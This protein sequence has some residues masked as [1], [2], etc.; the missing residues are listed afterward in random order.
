MNNIIRITIDEYITL[1]YKRYNVVIEDL[2]DIEDH[3][4]YQDISHIDIYIDSPLYWNNLYKLSLSL[5]VLRI[6]GNTLH[7][8]EQLPRVIDIRLNNI[9]IDSIPIEMI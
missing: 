2:V 6:S 7:G 8:I 1:S 9:N 3:I 5:K 4:N